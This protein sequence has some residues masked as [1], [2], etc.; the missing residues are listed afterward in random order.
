MYS[1]R[2]GGIRGGRIPFL[3]QVS[4]LLFSCSLAGAQSS[5]SVQTPEGAD[6]SDPLLARTLECSSQSQQ[7]A[8]QQ[9]SPGTQGTPTNPVVI[10]SSNYSDTEQYSR[11]TATQPALLPPEPLTE[12]QKFV[13]LSTGLVLPVYGADLFRRIPSTFAPVDMAPVSPDYVIGPGD[14]LRIRV[15]GQ[16]SIQANV[17]VDRS[18]EVYLPQVGQVH[19]AD[20]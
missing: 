12:F 18:G 11:Q 3:R 8:P 5:P 6:C 1:P 15:W 9:I 2:C 19:V 13:A 10:P 4:F 7:S 14:E 20:L 16:V 17:R